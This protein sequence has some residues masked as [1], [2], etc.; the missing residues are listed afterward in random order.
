MTD[1]PTLCLIHGH[2]VDPSIW[3][4]VYDELSA[5]V[6]I[7]KPNFSTSSSHETVEAYAE[8]LYSLLQTAGIQKV[9]LIGHSMGGYIALAFAAKY[10]EMM[11]GLGLFHSTAFPDDEA[12]KPKREQAIAR[13]T[14]EGTSAFIDSAVPNM[15][16]DEHKTSMPA[17]V[18]AV[19]TK[20]KQ[21]PAEALIAGIK[22]IQAR[23]DRTLVLKNA[24][25][26]VLI[27]AGKDDKLV[28]FEKSKE[29]FDMPSNVQTT[30]LEHSGHLGMLEE[31]AE[32]VNAI[33]R[34][35]IKVLAV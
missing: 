20:G 34:F 21:L 10:P 14:S 12:R 32:S 22:A 8:E 7:I 18:D 16:S 1:Q 35:L 27:I 6:Q 15:F 28:P 5:D 33:R 24:A 30:V 17:L 26:P 9:V 25:Y 3:D 4:A 11:A 23:P 13:L 19:V 2:G 29:L 31:P